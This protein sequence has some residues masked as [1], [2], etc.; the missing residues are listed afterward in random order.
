MLFSDCHAQSNYC[1]ARKASL[2]I[3]VSIIAGVGVE[4]SALVFLSVLV[5]MSNVT[6]DSKVSENTTHE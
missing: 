2:L 6:A 4:Y 3:N 1:N 5:F